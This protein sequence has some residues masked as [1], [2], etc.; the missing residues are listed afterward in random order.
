M[1]FDTN[2]EVWGILNLTP[3]SFYS[4]SRSSDKDIVER[5]TGML[6]SGATRIDI[7]AESTRPF[8][9]SIDADEEWDRLQKPLRLLL[10]EW[11]D[12]LFSASISLDTRNAKTVQRALE[13]GVNVFNDVS[14]GSD[15]EYIDLIAE[16][17]A[18]VV[19]MHTQGTPENMQVEP[20]YGNVTEEIMAFLKEKTNSFLEKGIQREQV[21]WDYGIGFG[22][23]V[24]HNRQLLVDT[25]EFASQGHRLLVGISRKSFLGKVLGI[26]APEERGNASLAGHAYLALHGADILRVHDVRETMEMVKLFYFLETGN[27]Y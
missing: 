1:A 20:E 27:V 15:E 17:G 18:T 10:Q 11:G 5:A 26:E 19:L 4:Q 25:A 22:K 23:T 14:G 6:K 8:S 13:M 21:I 9:R 3:N 12:Q 7:G 2:S 24:D 16:S